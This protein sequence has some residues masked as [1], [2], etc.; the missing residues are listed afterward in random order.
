[1]QLGN[2]LR[3]AAQRDPQK[4]AIIADDRNISFAEFDAEANRFANLL[5][6]AGITPGDRIASVLFNTPEYAI[7]H[8]GNARAGSVI[9][10]ISPM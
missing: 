6:N 4:T 1:M 2:I 9:V 7:I 5:L 8:F 10:H 3:L